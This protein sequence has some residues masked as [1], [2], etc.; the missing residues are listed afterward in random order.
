MGLD[1]PD[2]LEQPAVRFALVVSFAHGLA[3]ADLISA[4]VF[5]RPSVLSSPLAVASH[6]G[7]SFVAVLTL[8][9]MLRVLAD[10]PLRF[11]GKF[12]GKFEPGPLSAGLGGGLGL[13][14]GVVILRGLP[15]RARL[16]DD[17][18][19]L[20]LLLGMAAAAAAAAYR[21][22][23]A[24]DFR[25]P[26]GSGLVTALLIAPFPLWSL[27][28]CLWLRFF[29]IPGPFSFKS[30]VLYAAAATVMAGGT[31]LLARP[32]FFRRLPVLLLGATL[33]MAA[34]A[35]G[36]L[37]SRPAA[38]RLEPRGSKPHPVPRVI[39]ITI[40]TLRRD[41][42]SPDGS[43]AS[44]SPAAAELAR[45]GVEFTRAY[46]PA[47]WTPPSIAS[48][49]SGLS[50]D[51]HGVNRRQTV[52][53]ESAPMLAD[54]FAEA[55]YLTAAFGGNKLLTRQRA[56][57]RGFDHYWF[58]EG[59]TPHTLG[60]AA[61][62]A[63]LGPI[64]WSDQQRTE[65][66]TRRAESWLRLHSD[67]DFFLWLHYFDPHGP[68]IPPGEFL[69]ENARGRGVAAGLEFERGKRRARPFYSR[70]QQN[71]IRELYRGEV[72]YVD[73]RLARL[74][75]TLK[76]LDLYDDTLIVLTSDH[77][78]EFWEH[79]GTLHGHTFYNELLAVPLIFKL[80]SSEARTRSSI[81]AEVSTVSLTPTILDLCGL[82]FE[83][84]QFSAR[85]LAD[86]WT[87]EAEPKSPLPA[88][89]S[90]P[91]YFLNRHA[92]IENGWKY[93]RHPE[94]RHDELYNLKS[95]P[96]EKMNVASIEPERVA[97]LRS[98]LDEHRE[99]SR[100]LKA[101]LGIGD[102]ADPAAQEEM[103]RRLKSLGYTR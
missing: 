33:L 74:I 22:A 58:P 39:L 73:S 11:I 67:R 41:G 71:W 44:I 102:P 82:A 37:V 56:L 32:V 47:P 53:P 3:A 61:L 31:W 94:P 79:G 89:S 59:D 27:L 62:T 5:Q 9:V 93:I 2:P 15:P 98:R 86:F 91:L 72:R 63:L 90:S 60:V 25:S 20:V 96:A 46:S 24:V 28:I 81:P 49:F 8:Y 42:L 17:P 4:T 87:S 75:D 14:L 65:Q 50:P 52:F 38:G 66:I 80:P 34:M 77:G 29:V 100:A 45:D 40:D 85:S 12:L 36:S 1:R 55:G 51:V 13:T 99:Q 84:S 83:P 23:C 30:V 78:E 70:K 88:F 95:D 57:S 92:I 7:A 43:L 10:L 19:A 97:R 48:L 18:Y 103:Q 26:A 69:P 68:Y 21:L 6:L 16:L 101:R 64:S 35:A 54:F 76:R